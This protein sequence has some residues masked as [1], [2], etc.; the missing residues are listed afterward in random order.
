MPRRTREQKIIAQLR[1]ELN[2]ASPK[3][4]RPEPPVQVVPEIS[5]PEKIKPSPKVEAAEPAQPTTFLKRD[6]L[7][8]AA[9]ALAVTV[10]ELVISYLILSGTLKVI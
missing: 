6:L 7:K 4:P 1:R 8:F 2:Q 10:F 5:L 3:T 9:L